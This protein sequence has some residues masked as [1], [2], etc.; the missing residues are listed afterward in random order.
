[1]NEGKSRLIGEKMG[2]DIKNIIEFIF[3]EEFKDEFLK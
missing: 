3:F 1:M 2:L